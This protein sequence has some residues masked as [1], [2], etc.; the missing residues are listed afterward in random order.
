MRKSLVLACAAGLVFLPAAA[1]ASGSV[2]S[3]VSGQE[4]AWDTAAV[5]TTTTSWAPVPALAPRRPASAAH[6]VPTST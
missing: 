3:P 6:P 5:S 1:F 2:T 4:L